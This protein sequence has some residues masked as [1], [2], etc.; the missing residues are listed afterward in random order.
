MW[1]RRAFRGRAFIRLTI[2]T[3]SSRTLRRSFGIF[4][5]AKA[6][7]WIV[8]WVHMALGATYLTLDM[9]PLWRPVID[10]APSLHMPQQRSQ[11]K[12]F[13]L[14]NSFNLLKICSPVVWVG[15]WLLN[16]NSSWMSMFFTYRTYVY[17]WAQLATSVD[18][19]IWS[20]KNGLC[21][22]LS[23]TCSFTSCAMSEM[24]RLIVLS[25]SGTESILEAAASR[26]IMEHRSFAAGRINF[27]P[28]VCA[29][30]ALAIRNATRYEATV[31]FPF[32]LTKSSKK[33]FWPWKVWSFLW[34]NSGDFPATSTC[35][36]SRCRRSLAGL[37][38]PLATISWQTT[39]KGRGSSAGPVHV[40]PKLKY[41]S[42]Y[43]RLLGLSPEVEGFESEGLRNRSI[44]LIGI[45]L[46]WRAC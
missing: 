29:F 19:S 37:M 33:K 25:E 11:S 31:A 5:A 2:F 40:N 6:C 7:L 23:N 44:V 34:K 12:L 13:F 42:S 46:Y 32:N 24:R 30:P 20:A 3:A 17:S 15:K 26:S 21:L 35:L 1:K 4:L 27:S 45:Y 41:W 36:V 16:R 14:T 18:S 9:R 28:I 43:R 8:Q 22:T 10:F 38:L 39:H